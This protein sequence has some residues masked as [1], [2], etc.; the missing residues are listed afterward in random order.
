[1]NDYLYFAIQCASVIGSILAYSWLVRLRYTKRSISFCTF[2]WI[3]MILLAINLYIIGGNPISS[4]EP[5]IL[6]LFFCYAA[7]YSLEVLKEFERFEQLNTSEEQIDEFRKK[8]KKELVP[9]AIMFVIFILIVV[10]LDF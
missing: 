2:K 7:L 8:I 5:Y 6:F 9:W 10:I 4:W 3:N 1:M